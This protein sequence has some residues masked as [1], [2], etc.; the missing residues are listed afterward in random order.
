VRRENRAGWKYAAHKDERIAAIETPTRVVG[1]D[2][3]VPAAARWALANQSFDAAMGDEI[4]GL[5]ADLA[6]TLAET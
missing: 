4:R 2:C 3:D 5:V 1:I 6:R